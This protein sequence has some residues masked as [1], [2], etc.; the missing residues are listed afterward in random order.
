MLDTTGEG[1]PPSP[2]RIGEDIGEVR[3]YLELGCK[4]YNVLGRVEYSFYAYDYL[5]LNK[6]TRIFFVIVVK[7]SNMILG[8]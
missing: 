8:Q 7:F 2:I 4:R 1:R 5:Y 6:R 3:L